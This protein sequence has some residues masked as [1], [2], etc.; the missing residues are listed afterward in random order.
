M[1]GVDVENHLEKVGL[2]TDGEL[3]QPLV[4]KTVLYL[5]GSVLKLCRIADRQP[6]VLLLDVLI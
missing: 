1:I 6:S 5:P 4:K 3:T 2:C